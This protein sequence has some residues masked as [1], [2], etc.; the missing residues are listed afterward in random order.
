[1][2]SQQIT[3]RREVLLSL[4]EFLSGVKYPTIEGF[5]NWLEAEIEAEGNEESVVAESL[6]E[7]RRE[8]SRV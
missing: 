2:N 7:L 1:M 8:Q 3:I 6:D 4:D 5:K